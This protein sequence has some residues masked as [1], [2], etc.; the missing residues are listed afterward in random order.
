MALSRLVLRLMVGLLTASWAAGQAA[1][2]SPNLVLP[3]QQPPPDT[4]RLIALG[5][6][7]PTVAA[8]QVASSYLLQLGG[9]RN[10]LFD[11][12]TGSITNLYDAGVDLSTIDTVRPLD[13]T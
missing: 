7:T 12:G 5:T 10:I 13:A 4:I 3:G 8:S 9:T 2:V 6:G 1:R 11:A